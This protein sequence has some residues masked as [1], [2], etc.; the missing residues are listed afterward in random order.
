MSGTQ[1]IVHLSDTEDV[2]IEMLHQFVLRHDFGG[3]L[4]QSEQLQKHVD[5][6]H[7]LVAH[8]ELADVLQL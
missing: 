6:V 5:V 4:I 1:V 2:V 8:A 3:A 7:A